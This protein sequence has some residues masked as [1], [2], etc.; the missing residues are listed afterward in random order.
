VDSGFNGNSFSD[1]S[2]WAQDAPIRPVAPY[3][4]GI[5]QEAML[6]GQGMV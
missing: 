5:S 6:Y 2:L 1:C 3:K 4:L